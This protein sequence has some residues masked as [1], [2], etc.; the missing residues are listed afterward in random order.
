MATRISADLFVSPAEDRAIKA[1]ADR[2]GLSKRAWITQIVR[3]RINQTDDT[4][5]VERLIERLDTE[6]RARSAQTTDQAVEVIRLEA[7][8]LTDYIVEAMH[9]AMPQPAPAAAPEPTAEWGEL[10]ALLHKIAAKVASRTQVDA[11]LTEQTIKHL[12]RCRTEFDAAQNNVKRVKE[13]ENALIRT[14]EHTESIIPQLDDLFALLQ[15][16]TG[17]AYP[18]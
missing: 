15:P 8:R 16:I 6:T 9:K 7:A 17:I 18:K 4:Q 2:V 13:K 5:R 10:V 3:D 14:L 11:A 1:A 12:A